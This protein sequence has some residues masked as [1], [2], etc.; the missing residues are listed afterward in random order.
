MNFSAYPRSCRRQ[1]RRWPLNLFCN[2]LDIAALN[3][4]TVF[5]QVY[6]DSHSTQGSRRRRF[7]TDLANSLDL[8][9]HEDKTEN[10]PTAKSHKRSY[11][12]MWLDLFQ[13]FPRD[14]TLLKRKPCVLCMHSK[15]RKVSKCCRPV[16]PE[17]SISTITCNECYK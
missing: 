8:S 2:R 1:T 3:A 14:N 16:C 7:I 11:G 15:D 6:P 13:C 17:H 9:T 10:P 5:G 12:E 4:Y